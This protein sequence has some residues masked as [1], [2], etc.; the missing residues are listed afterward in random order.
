MKTFKEFS[1]NESQ[2]VPITDLEQDEQKVLAKI[3][4]AFKAKKNLKNDDITLHGG[5]HGRIVDFKH[6]LGDFGGS[7]P[8]LFMPELK[9]IAAL[10]VRWVSIESDYATV[11][12]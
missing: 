6:G 4:N 3:L 1:V 5:I 11:G 7:A 8:R 10:K 2:Q 9:K 12:F